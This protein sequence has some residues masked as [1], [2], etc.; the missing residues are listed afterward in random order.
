MY[1][2]ARVP[3]AAESDAPLRPRRRDPS[4][5]ANAIPVAGTLKVTGDGLRIQ[6]LAERWRR[7]VW[8]DAPEFWIRAPEFQEGLRN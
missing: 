1:C 5:T 7:W 8:V 2:A 3:A 6:H 4:V